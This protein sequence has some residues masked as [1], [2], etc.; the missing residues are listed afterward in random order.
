MPGVGWDERARADLRAVVSY[1][2]PRNPK[3]AQSLKDLIENAT[4]RLS[5]FPYSHRPGRVPGTRELVV[6]PNYIVI[7]RI[8]TD[9][10]RI[11]RILHARQ[12]YP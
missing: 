2:A 3:A 6:H 11:L 12:Q 5:A 9:L 7:Y 1:V 10:I 8:E 4:E